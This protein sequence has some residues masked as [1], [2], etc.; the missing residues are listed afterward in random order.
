MRLRGLIGRAYAMDLAVLGQA[1]DAVVCT[2]SAMACRLV[3]VIM[4]WEAAV[5][6]ARWVN[7][8]GEY[9]WTAG[10]SVQ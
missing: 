7:I 6:Q 10:L 1:T 9:S 8:D 3:A 2:L 4:G 5:D